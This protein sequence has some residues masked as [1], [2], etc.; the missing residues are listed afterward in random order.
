MSIIEIE[1]ANALGVTWLAQ[2]SNVHINL[3]NLAES[4]ER[5][6]EN[7]KDSYVRGLMLSPSNVQSDHKPPYKFN[8][9][10]QWVQDTISLLSFFLGL[11][12]NEEV[13]VSII[14]MIYSIYFQVALV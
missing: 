8:I 12:S 7:K 9:F 11:Q 6:L 4:Y 3:E 1:F 14:E 2:N 5:L 10:L 13:G